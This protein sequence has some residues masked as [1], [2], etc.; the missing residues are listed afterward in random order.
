IAARLTWAD[1]S[2]KMLSPQ[3]WPTA[4]K[5]NLPTRLVI[6]N[7]LVS[8]STHSALAK[9]MTKSWNARFVKSS[10]SNRLRLSNSSTYCAQYIGKLL[11]TDTSVELMIS[12]PLLGNGRIGRR[13]CGRQHDKS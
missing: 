8:A 10:I 9:W 3:G 1:G 7:P 2:Q 6:Q 5:C 13:H 4:A 11:T 12:M